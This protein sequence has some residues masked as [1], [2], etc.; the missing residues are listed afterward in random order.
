M[1]KALIL[2]LVTLLLISATSCSAHIDSA[3]ESALSDSKPQ[4]NQDMKEWLKTANLAAKETP[5]ELYQKALSE[6]TL[7]VYSNSTRIIDVKESFEKHYPGLTVYVEDIRSADLLNILSSNFT[8]KEYPCDI[9]LCDDNGVL[10]QELLARGVVFT[11]VPYDI[12]NKISPENRGEFLPAVIELQQAFYNSEVYDAPPIHN[13]WELTEDK[14][15]DKVVMPSPFSSISSMGFF[16]MIL[17]NSEIMEESYYDLYGK[18]LNLQPNETAGKAFW[19]MLFDNGL[20]LVGSSDEVHEMIGT[21]GQTDPPVGIMISSKIRMR[22]LGYDIKP[23][24]DM[25]GFSGVYSSNN[26]MIAGGCKN[27]NSAKL[28]TRW[29]LG[30]SDGQGEGSRPYLQNGAWSARSDVSSQSEKKLDEIEYLEL[31]TKY[32]YENRNSIEDLL[33][34][35]IN[36][37]SEGSIS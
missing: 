15:R 2:I 19:R 24:F 33:D 23:I 17:R 5:D 8:A 6:D 14:Y 21:P 7:I 32:I 30:E 34:E 10:S 18:P 12:E 31:D 16:S 22:D 36:D 20:I 26:I 1:K 27:T 13:W 4:M 25:D 28:F 9:V 29:I 3:Q 35:L 37:Q 11:Y